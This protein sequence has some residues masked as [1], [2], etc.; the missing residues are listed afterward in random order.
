[1]ADYQALLADLEAEQSA[2]DGVVAD[3]DDEGWGTA[4][5]AAGWDVRDTIAHLALSE[6]LATTALTDAAAFEIGLAELVQDIAATET[7]LTERGRSMPGTEVLAWWRRARAGTLVELHRR[8]ARDRIP[9]IAGPMSAMSFATAR[10]METWAHGQDVAD[11]LVV[12][13]VATARLRH[14]AELGVR[15]RTFSFAVRA[16]PV[17]DDDVL[18]ELDAPDGTTWSWGASSVDIVRGPARDFCLVVTQRRHPIDTALEVSGDAARAW[19]AAAQA[20]AGPPT[21]QRAPSGS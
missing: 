3:L 1:V 9:W 15:T 8:G 17:P 7:A 4:T 19:I 18:V 21:E 10:L 16:L 2:L 12:P 5:P 20:F 6:D 14:I 13:S 11:G